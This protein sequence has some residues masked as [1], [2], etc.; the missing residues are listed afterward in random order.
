MFERMTEKEVQA[1]FEI[2]D[3]QASIRPWLKQG[4]TWQTG[5]AG[6]PELVGALGLQDIVVAN[7]FLC[8]M[9]PEAAERC[10]RNV[11]RTVKPGGYL[12]V[13]GV[14]LRMRTRVARSLGWK[15]VEDLV[16]EVHEGDASLR[17]GWPFGWWGLEPFSTDLP[18][19]KIRYAC[20]FQIGEAP[21]RMRSEEGEVLPKFHG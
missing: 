20:V 10:L 19:W 3:D 6:D 8:H 2:D 14:D 11:A 15:P 12:F 5:D 4:I 9:A 18:D 13:S 16:R 21:T 7:R 17:N 1:M